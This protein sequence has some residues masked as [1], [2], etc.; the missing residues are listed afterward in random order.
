MLNRIIDFTLA[1]RWL[2][3]IGIL[4]LLA[5]GGYALYTIPVEAFPDLTNNQVVVVTDAPSLP[6]V[7][8]NSSSPTR[9]SAPCWDCQI[10]KKCALY[11]T[12]VFRWLRSCLTIPCLCT[13]PASW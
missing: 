10:S 9:S 6:R 12:L 5:G 7:K 3:L 4:I 8:S 13:S 11:R 1:Y 2:V